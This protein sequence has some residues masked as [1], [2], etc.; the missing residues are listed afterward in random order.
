M[1]FLAVF[2][3][4]LAEYQLEHKIEKEKG[5]QYISSFYEDLKAD[6]S[7]LTGI[8]TLYQKKVDVLNGASQCYDSLDKQKSFFNP[9][10]AELVWQTDGFPDFIAA[11]RTL[12][13][14]KNAGGLRLLKQADADSILVYDK[15]LRDYSLSEQTGFQEIQKKVF[16]AIIPLLNYK[17]LRLKKPDPAVPFLFTTNPEI[18]NRYFVLLEGYKNSCAVNIQ[19]L[20]LTN[21]KAGSLIQYLKSKYHLK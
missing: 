3:G 6:T 1:L 10:I 16:E 11:D 14:L 20:R 18:I 5:L 21:E 7:T 9:C 13:Q 8:I 4:F 2:C 12:S 19:K 17:N 15:M